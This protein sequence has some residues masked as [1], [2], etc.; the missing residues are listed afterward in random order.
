VA[1]GVEPEVQRLRTARSVSLVRAVLALLFGL[2]A[3]AWPFMLPFAMRFLFAVYAL[4]DG[5]AALVGVRAAA[6]RGRLW[7]GLQGGVAIAAALVAWVGV[8]LGEEPLRRVLAG[9][10][11]AD[12]LLRAAA[13]AAS[14]R[15][16]GLLQAVASVGFGLFLLSGPGSHRS[17]WILATGAYGVCL[18]VITAAA[19]YLARP[20]QAV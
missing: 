6:E 7:L 10:A 3:L 1:L 8:P 12:G 9:W 13:H 15:T 2:P 5:V 11:F 18:G 19:A 20:R 17:G 4:A 14:S 16:L